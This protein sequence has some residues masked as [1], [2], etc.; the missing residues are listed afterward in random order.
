MKPASTVRSVI[1]SLLVASTV[2]ST[3]GAAEFRQLKIGSDYQLR[4]STTVIPGDH[5]RLV[6]LIDAQ[7]N[8]PD[9]IQVDTTS[10][11][12]AE[13]MRIGHYIRNR[14][15]SVAAGKSCANTCFV[16]WAGG[17]LRQ[18]NGPVNVRIAPGQVSQESVETYLTD[19]EIP[20][21]IIA[22]ALSRDS[23]DD[24]VVPVE[25]VTAGFGAYSPAHRQWLAER[26]GEL[27]T[28]EEQDLNAIR[29]LK[30]MED[31]LNAM[32]SG[33]GGNAMFTVSAETQQLAARAR[34]I[35]EDARLALQQQA[36]DHRR[37]QKTR[38]TTARKQAYSFGE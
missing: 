35:P 36:E 32:G 17:V 21:A 1:M 31:S 18:A 29:A 12:V 9:A 7:G 5:D 23:A 16:I 10:G 2:F 37:C 15:L 34:E 3:A 27:T 38:V 28:S 30:S 33:M 11:D 6:E 25:I 19:M 20:A 13:S 22:T 24:P 8:Y 4:I 14:M 26:C